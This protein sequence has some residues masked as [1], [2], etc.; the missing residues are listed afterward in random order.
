MANELKFGNPIVVGSAS[1]DPATG[2]NGELYYN[3]VSNKIRQYI[4]G[5]WVDVGSGSASLTGQSLNNHNVIVGNGSNLSAA[6]D[7]NAAGDVLADS[8]TALTVK[9]S[10]ITNAKMADMAAHT[11]KG[12]NGGSP[13]APSD[14]TVSQVNTMLGDVLADGSV[15]F[16]ADQSM[17]S[18]KLTNVT[19]PTAAQDAATK[20]YV[21][22]IAQGITWKNAVRSATT[23]VLAAYTYN[24]GSSG[25]GAT[26]T[27]NANGALAAQ[28][29]VTLVV[30]D[31]LLV[32][33]ETAGNQPNNGIYVVTQV[34]DGSNPF[35][36]TRATDLDVAAEF[37]AAAT[38]VGPEAS[39]QAGYG[40]RQ[41]TA[42]PITVGTS[43]ISF[44]NFVIGTSYNFNNGLA[45]SGSTVNVVPGDASLVASAGSLEVQE[46]PAG[47]IITGGSG[48]KVQ[49]ETS[50]P[51]LQISANKLGA[52]LDGAGAIVTGASG[53]KVQLE[54]SNPSLQIS[55]DALGVKLDPAGAIVS[56][57]AG[58]AVQ[59]ESS[60]PT[61]QISTDKLGVKLD[62]SRAITT[63]ASGVGVNVDGT[64]IDIAGNAIE[65]KAGG[66]S[67]TQ[68]AAAAAIA[69]SKLAALNVDRIPSTDHTTGFL[70]DT[71]AANDK[72]LIS[73]SLQRGTSTSAFITE[74]Y[75]DATS[76][77]DNSGP[78]AVA[79]F[80][81]AHASFTGEEI[82]YVIS[83]GAGT[84][85][86][87]MG[88]LRIVSNG[89][90]TSITDLFSETADCGITWSASIS[91]ANTLVSYTA[92][93]QG[94]N[95]TLRADVKVFRK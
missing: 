75:V 30:N 72:L 61:L 51:T 46:D 74:K 88:T 83:T 36:L 67:N 86:V 8:S 15:P 69:L 48:I 28:D 65:V 7:T 70:T 66:I 20:S 27:A 58:V 91:G 95:R 25:V 68:V 73:N 9:N 24:N 11:L 33:N 41:G 31:R 19:N 44:V 10:A 32:K 94:S 53:L 77:V 56:G 43:N 52:K 23:G 71:D 76:L 81:F 84:P 79:A 13:A 40:Y 39:T 82:S 38:Q 45:L 14:L 64:T 3:T 90:N 59:L 93:N 35:I 87:R 42:G 6:V 54:S 34:G 17:G 21:D 4:N 60:N 78:T 16:T 2:Y 85:D 80:Q 49:L 22:T 18:H 50:N 5:G 26:I 57:A 89:T 37:V 92:S 12:N 1:S 47:A 62:G 63:G 29:G 55:T